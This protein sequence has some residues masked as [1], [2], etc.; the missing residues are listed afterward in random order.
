ML[1]INSLFVNR[2]SVKRFAA[3]ITT[4]LVAN[5]VEKIFASFQI[6]YKLSPKIHYQ[7]T[8][9]KHKFKNHEMLMML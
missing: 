1:G 8:K 2:F 7:E 3:H 5:I 6:K 4:N 9:S